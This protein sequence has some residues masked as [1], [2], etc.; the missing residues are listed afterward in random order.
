M[1]LA[2]LL[3][4]KKLEKKADINLE[5]SSGRTALHLAAE[6]GNLEVA[7]LLLENKADINLQDS[8]DKTALDVANRKGNVK[9]MH[10][11]ENRA[12]ADSAET[13]VTHTNKT[14]IP[15]YCSESPALRFVETVR[16]KQKGSSGA[17]R[18]TKGR[19]I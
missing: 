3:L 9:I 2:K 8:F 6:N 1:E 14:S 18:T 10:L 4:D 5:D 19:V 13:I 11:L 7:E 16:Q 15:I 17:T 12:N